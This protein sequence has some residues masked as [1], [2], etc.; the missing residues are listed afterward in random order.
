MFRAWNKDLPETIELCPVQLPGRET[1]AMEPACSRIEP[2]IALLS[3][4]I[5]PL[6]DLPYFFFGHSMGALIAFVTT[7]AA[8][9]R[10]D[11]LSHS[12][13]RQGSY[14]HAIGRLRRSYD[15]DGRLTSQPPSAMAAHPVTGPLWATPAALAARPELANLLA[16]PAEASP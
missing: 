5:R 16:Q 14:E 15:Q 12:Q 7:A 6:L 10:F 9:Y 13:T 4:A 3:E 1:R 11:G 8:R 2:L